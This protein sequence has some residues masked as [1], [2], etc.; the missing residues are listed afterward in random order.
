MCDHSLCVATCNIFHIDILCEASR[1]QQ[2]FAEIQTFA[3][4][5]LH[6]KNQRRKQLQGKLETNVKAQNPQHLTD[7]F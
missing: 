1:E 5:I 6:T 4:W 7:F 2:E 3:S